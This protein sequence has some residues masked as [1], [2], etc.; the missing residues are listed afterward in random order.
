MDEFCCFPHE[1][2]DVSSVSAEIELARDSQRCVLLRLGRKRIHERLVG[3]TLYQSVAE[4]IYRY[5]ENDVV[6]GKLG[7]KV[8][9]AKTQPGASARP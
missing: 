3:K 5:A 9:C 1:T 2:R 4:R 7:G 6:V 8:G